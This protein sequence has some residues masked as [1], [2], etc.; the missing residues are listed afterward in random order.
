MDQRVCDICHRPAFFLANQWNKA[1]DAANSPFTIT[2]LYLQQ[3]HP[4]F[5][6]GDT[7]LELF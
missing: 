1:V 6:G 2:L 4:A 7:S 5:G 3:L